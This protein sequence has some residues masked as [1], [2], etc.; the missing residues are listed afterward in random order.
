MKNMKNALMLQ[1]WYSKIS[2]HWYPWL[3][4]ELEARGYQTQFPDIAEFRK[5][6]P[7]LSIILRDVENLRCINR[8]TM[9]VSHSLGCLAALRLAETHPYD[10]LILVSGWDYNDLTEAHQS[11]WKTPVDHAA[12]KKNGKRV[13]VIHSDND[14][15]ITAFSA[16]EMSKRLGGTFVCVKNGGHLTAQYGFTTL[17][18]IVPYL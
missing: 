4:N 3:K 8:D 1:C 17:P 15:Y 16:E 6:A 13:I 12:I 5:D 9:M 7:D 2:D 18:A 11:F 14:P 10:T